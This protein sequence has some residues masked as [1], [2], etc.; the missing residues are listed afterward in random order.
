MPDSP[1]NS[2]GQEMSKD[3]PVSPDVTQ[4]GSSSSGEGMPSV[5]GCGLSEMLSE[6]PESYQTQEIT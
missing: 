1:L 4:L 2:G 5:A 3:N 6:G